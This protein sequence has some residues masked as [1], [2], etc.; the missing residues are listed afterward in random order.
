MENSM[1]PSHEN[2]VITKEEGGGALLLQGEDYLNHEINYDD[3]SQKI[4]STQKT[5]SGH[6][7]YSHGHASTSFQLDIKYYL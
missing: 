1:I 5:P 3:S 6:Q 4:A 2:Y 7:K